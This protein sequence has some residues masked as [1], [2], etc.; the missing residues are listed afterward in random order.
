TESSRG[1]VSTSQSAT[2]LQPGP[3][4]AKPS[5]SFTYLWTGRTFRSYLS[6]STNSDEQAVATSDTWSFLRI[7]ARSNSTTTISKTSPSFVTSPVPDS[8]SADRGTSKT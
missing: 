8:I 3:K 7:S 1:T 2:D 5:V 6:R 4:A